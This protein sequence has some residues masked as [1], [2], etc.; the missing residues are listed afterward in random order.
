MASPN[1][2]RCKDMYKMLYYLMELYETTPEELKPYL[3]SFIENETE[4]NATAFSI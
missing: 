3:L 2:K 1:I 4:G